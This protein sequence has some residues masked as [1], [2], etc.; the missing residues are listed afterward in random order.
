MLQNTGYLLLATTRKL[1][2]SLVLRQCQSQDHKHSISKRGAGPICRCGL[3]W[4]QWFGSNT[5][6]LFPC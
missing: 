5:N 3:I 6:D 2:L 4:D 1:A